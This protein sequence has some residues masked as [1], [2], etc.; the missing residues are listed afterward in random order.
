MEP[1][2]HDVNATPVLAG[3]GSIVTSNRTVLVAG[4][5]GGIGEGVARALLRAGRPVVAVGRNAGRLDAL[6]HHL[7]DASTGRL[8]T[9]VGD[10]GGRDTGGLARSIAEHGPL[11]GAVVSIGA[12][13]GGG[14]LLE[15]DDDAWDRGVADNLTSHFRALRTLVPLV[16]RRGALAHLSGLSADMP[17]PGAALVGATNAA[18]KSLVLSLAAERSGVGPRVYE[19][20]LGPI[21]T[22]PRKAAGHDDPGWF[23]AEDVGRHALELIDGTGPGAGESLH[24]LVDRAGGISAGPPGGAPG[25]RA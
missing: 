9:L 4:A 2:D 16:D 23:A 22:R 20:I 24:Y 1:D 12:W 5:T 18:K 13:G 7:A 21:R 10:L 25:S 14:P 11:A 8:F 3:G 15:L 17:F 19:L 6:R